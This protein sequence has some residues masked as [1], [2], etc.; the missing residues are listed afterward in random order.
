MGVC[1]IRAPQ[2]C[3]SSHPPH[4]KGLALQLEQR[5]TNQK[6]KQAINAQ[7]KFNPPTG[8]NQDHSKLDLGKVLSRCQQPPGHQMIHPDPIKGQQPDQLTRPDPRRWHLTHDARQK[9]K[10]PTGWNADHSKLD[11]GQALSGL[12]QPTGARWSLQLNLSG[13]SCNLQC[14][15]INSSRVLWANTPSK[16][17]ILDCVK[18][19][20]TPS[21]IWKIL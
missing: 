21:C 5:R 18:P 4:P 8:W 19:M 2:A 16:S 7:P 6:H 15:Q 11:L 14:W 10:Q 17:R 1:L 13:W 9:L 20:T 3:P 12:Q